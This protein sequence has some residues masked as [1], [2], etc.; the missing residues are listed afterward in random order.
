[1]FAVKKAAFRVVRAG[2]GFIR[3]TLCPINNRR[4]SRFGIWDTVE[5]VVL[6]AGVV[7][8]MRFL[9]AH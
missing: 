4:E 3:T 1:L 9:L 5:V 2:S 8:A 7:L 6:V